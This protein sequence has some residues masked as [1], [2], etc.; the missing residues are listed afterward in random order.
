MTGSEVRRIF[1]KYFESKGHTVLPSSSLVSEGDPTLLFTNAGM[2]QFKKIFTGEEKRDFKRA[3]TA[4]KCMRAGGKHNDFENVGRTARHHTFF[5]MLGNFS[6]GDYFKKEA[7]EFAWK[8]ITDIFK[9]ERKRLWITVYK[10]DDEAFNFWKKI[11]LPEARIIKMDE[12]DN[13]WSM[14]DTG[15]CGPCSELI[16]DQGKDVG[17]GRPE[18][19]VACDCDRFLEIWNLVFMQYERFHD[20][21]LLP[22]PQPSIDTGMGLERITAVIQGAKS[23]YDTD[24]FKDI[25]SSTEKLS[26]KRYGE[27]RNNDIAMRVIADHIRSIFFLIADGV[28][29][30]NEGR[31]YVLRRIIRR[32]ARFGKKLDMPS[33]F[34]IKLSSS[35]ERTLSDQYPEIV[36]RR[37]IINSIIEPEEEK[38]SE[39]LEKGIEIFNEEIKK[40]S[41]GILPGELAFKL[42]DTYGF[43]VDI[44]E[45]MAGEA[46][47]YFDRKGFELALGGQRKRSRLGM[48]QVETKTQNIYSEILSGGFGVEFLGYETTEQ[49]GRIK[50]I[51][52]NGQFLKEAK[53]GD[54][55]EIVTDRTPFYGE[56]GGQIGDTG[57]ILGDSFEGEVFDTIKPHTNLIVHRCRIKKGVVSLNSK[58]LLKVD[59]KRRSDIASNHTA[60]HL[61][62]SALRRVLGEH[63]RQ[64]GSL[65]A[66][67]RFRFDFS[68]HTQLSDE[69]LL[70]IEDLVNEKIKEGVPV[71]TRIMGYNEALSMGALAFFD[72]KYGE[73][74][75]LVNIN[76]FSKEL[77][78]GTHVNNTA[79]IGIFKIIS[80]SGI[81][82]GIRRIEA[83]TGR[84]VLNYLRILEMR[85]QKISGT[86]NTS[87]E[88]IIDRIKKMQE[89]IKAL[90]KEREQLKKQLI[91][92]GSV[93]KKEWKKEINGI[94]III[95]HLEDLDEKAMLELS[96]RHKMN[97]SPCLLFLIS[98]R[99]GK[100]FFLASASKELS[101][102]FD[103]SE[104][105][106]RVATVLDGRGGGKKELARGSGTAIERIEEAVK[107]AFN[108]VEERA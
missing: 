100:L 17:C 24:L 72:E 34:L 69:E 70:K 6:F 49:E 43:P 101:D 89:T 12:K 82:A 45:D 96:D 93:I 62:H 15:P 95:Q 35:V 94:K 91:S 107:E 84:W 50:F 98:E 47:L 27:N 66:P 30:S 11:G 59:A 29:P 16:Y 79:D 99:Q 97:I 80:D 90:E 65:V 31:G 92:R 83:L 71:E 64:S 60:T 8:L 63:V 75:R 22:L 85:I 25:I 58:V 81:S 28:V 53:A 105:L 44:T 103:A 10:E 68:H 46:G 14:G 57:I 55:I 26:N 88:G 20:G 41:N 78:G 67:E 5:E 39:T 73:K 19:A 104:W 77:C 3:T 4:Q 106:K 61:L 32:A 102:R 56:S 38:F 21:K 48:K 2:V 86:L 18:C 87:S 37:N 7:I 54:E 23:N 33:P 1:L 42:Y 36:S 76:K 108:W 13:F 52:K 51:T 40:I 74:V 9:L